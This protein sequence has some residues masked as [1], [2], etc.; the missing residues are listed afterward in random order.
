MKSPASKLR[1]THG[2]GKEWVGPGGWKQ[3]RMVVVVGVY[4][5]LGEV[6][7]GIRLKKSGLH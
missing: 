4:L 2:G 7:D 3:W 5:G 6:E 1:P